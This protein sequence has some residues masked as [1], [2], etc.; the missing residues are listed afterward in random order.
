MSNIATETI[1]KLRH[2][3]NEIRRLFLQKIPKWLADKKQFDKTQWGF[4]EGDNDGWYKGQ[5]ITIHFGAWCG[6]YGNSSVYKEI[7]LDGEVFRNHFLS[8]LNKNK[9]A[10]MLSVADSI[11]NE[12]KSLKA[13]AEA[14]LN[15]Q[16]SNL[17]ELEK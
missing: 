13:D 15:K 8:Y 5:T 2:D 10:I 9:E 4:V 3:V 6:V 7:D 11:E 1:K 12:A 16:L 17:A 14:E